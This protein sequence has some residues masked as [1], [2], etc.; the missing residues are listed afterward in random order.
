MMKL[1]E[2]YRAGLKVYTSL[3]KE[4]L[5]E[6][7]SKKFLGKKRKKC[8]KVYEKSIVWQENDLVERNKIKNISS[9]DRRTGR[10]IYV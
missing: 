9:M 8:T 2:Y 10:C 5:G 4:E 1:N 6:R 7:G 3:I